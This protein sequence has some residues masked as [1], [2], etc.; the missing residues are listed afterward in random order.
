VPLL[1]LVGLIV[2]PARE[3]S[4][5]GIGGYASAQTGKA[6]WDVVLAEPI[7]FDEDEFGADGDAL[8]YGVGFALDTAPARSAAFNYRL[9]I[10][11]EKFEADW[12]DYFF[13]I[14]GPFN[15]S[16]DL[17]PRLTLGFTG[18]FVFS[19]YVGVIDM[20]DNDALTGTSST[21]FFNVSVMARAG[22]DAY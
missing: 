10:G 13:D 17:G 15:D 8:R 22:G 21:A 5:I 1:V 19:G 11:A 20:I 4:A 18:G 2:I 14:V 6:D 16:L 12:E 9:N 7:V 3:A